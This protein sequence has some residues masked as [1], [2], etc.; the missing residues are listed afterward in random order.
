MWNR[1]PNPQE[2]HVAHKMSIAIRK[3]Y[4]TIAGAVPEDEEN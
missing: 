2:K 3:I 4:N 1:S